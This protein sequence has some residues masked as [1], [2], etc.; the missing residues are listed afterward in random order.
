MNKKMVYE[1]GRRGYAVDPQ[2]VGEAVKRIAKR[3]GCCAPEQLVGVASDETSPL[4]R[5]FTWDDAK[6]AVNWRTH[7]ARQVIGSLTV[8]VMVDDHE[9]RAPAFI[10]VGHTSQTQTAGEGY[11]PLSVVQQTPEFHTEALEE[12]ISRMEA[13][14][15]RYAA[16]EGLA[17]VWEALDRIKAA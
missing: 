4:H 15:R 7:E 14:R 10:S 13:L 1:W 9:E 16:V 11:R 8:K 17:P 2:V 12:V 6:A 3:D 5:L